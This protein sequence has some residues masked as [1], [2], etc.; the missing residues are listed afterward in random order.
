MAS[1]FAAGMALSG[2]LK[3]VKAMILADMIGP[4]GLKIKRD[5]NST[6]WLVDLLWATAARLGYRHVFVSEPYPISGD[7][8]L[9]FIRRGVGA[10]DIIDFEVD[11]IYWHTPRDTLD[12]VDPSSLAIVGHVFL[13]SLPD[14][15]KK[16]RQ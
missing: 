7:D 4:A 12:K 11:P 3:R 14:L 6:K 13:E 16:F 1:A 8:H 5:T 10:C 2:E 9:S 15:E